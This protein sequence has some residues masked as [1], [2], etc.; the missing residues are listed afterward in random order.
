V[1]YIYQEKAQTNVC[2]SIWADF[3]S[4]IGRTWL[5]RQ[6]WFTD[7]VLLYHVT[8]TRL[9]SR[10]GQAPFSYPP[11]VPPLYSQVHPSGKRFFLAQF[12]L[13]Q[14]YRLSI[15]INITSYS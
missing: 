9:V 2:M 4:G 8:C 12:L 5:H 7:T 13:K 1:Y 15:I 11:W 3:C 14:S 6:T 10:F